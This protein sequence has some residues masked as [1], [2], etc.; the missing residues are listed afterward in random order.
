MEHVC[1]PR[2]ENISDDALSVSGE[3]N[4]QAEHFK[5][6]APNVERKDKKQILKLQG[7]QFDKYNVTA[8]KMMG[9][10][11]HFFVKFS[12]LFLKPPTTL[13]G[14]ITPCFSSL[15]S[16]ACFPCKIVAKRIF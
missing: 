1:T 16:W 15:N 6:R 13:L 8:G 2:S 11:K 5:K 7:Y 14:V 4:T 12:C 9:G 10:E 3:T